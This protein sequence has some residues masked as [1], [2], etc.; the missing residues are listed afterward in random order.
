MFA[1]ADLAG[2]PHDQA[3]LFIN[4]LL[5][6]GSWLQTGE[7]IEWLDV[8]SVRA[9]FSEEA[10]QTYLLAFADQ[11]DSTNTHLMQRAA[12][13]APHGLVLGCEW[14]LAAR[15]RL[16][17]R[18]QM[19]LGGNLAFSILWRFNCGLGDLSGLSLAVGVAIVRVLRR[20]AIP[21]QLKWPGGCAVERQETGRN[22]DRT[23]RRRQRWGRLPVVI[24][25]GINLISPDGVDPAVIS[26]PQDHGLPGRNQLLA[27]MLNSLHDVL[28]TFPATRL[29][30]TE[31]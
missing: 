5:C 6:Q 31:D 22:S 19:K 9:G 21:A 13:G 30:S 24:G 7:P 17:R 29:C 11:I 16:G 26:L 25:I 23:D 4:G 2:S 27:E 20:Y 18:W 10:A 15:G 3:R 14:Q 12:D 28:E 8:A 1:H